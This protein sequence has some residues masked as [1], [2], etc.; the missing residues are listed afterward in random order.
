ME[1]KDGYRQ[2]EVGV[3]P[4]DW[5][6]FNLASLSTFITKGSTPTTYGFSWQQAGILF[7]RSE[8]VSDNGLDLAQSMYISAAA[9]VSLRRSQVK[10]G[11]ILITITGN[12][13]RVA[14]FRIAEE[15]NI[16]QHIAR[17][18]ITS[19]AALRD[20]VYHFLSLPV[21]RARL[22]LITT[23]QAYPQIS[24]KQVRE[25]PV[26]LPPTKAEQE[27]IAE[28]LSDADALIESLEQ[29][30][31]KKRQIKQ[32]AMQELLTGKR[33]LP[34]FEIKPGDKQS[35]VGVIPEDWK[36]VPLSSL[37]EFRNGVNAD[38]KA[39]GTGLPFIN[40]LEIITKSHLNA[41][42]I[43][44]RISLP[45]SACDVYGIR[46]GD[47][48]FN[49]TS[50]TQGEIG[51]ASVFLDDEPVVFGGF[52]IRARPIY[53]AAFDSDYAGYALRSPSVRRQISARGQGAIRTNV[54][55]TDLRTVLLPLPTLLEQ[56]A[57]AAILAGID[58]EIAAFE[59]K[60]A[61][62][63]QIKQGMM[64]ELLTGRIRLI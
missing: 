30:F 43:P 40:V 31:A 20:F 38:K 34:G 17:V 26:P 28:A 47:L 42:D 57:I 5:T 41:S 8:C 15:T 1:V 29:L 39:Y 61:K 51:L 64:Q 58:D 13:G 55:Q 56:G 52:V 46:R 35:E 22:T 37:L 10:E 48:I 33:R 60:L 11:D 59:A 12:V 18:R 24:L 50:E 36:V 16:N 6:L 49:R 2:T 45:K 25:A 9:H 21:C 44:G 27:A 54:G 4:E 3:I 32:G 23:G 53:G 62:A 14:L 19:A 7:L 63:R